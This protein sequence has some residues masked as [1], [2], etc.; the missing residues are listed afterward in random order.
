[1]SLINQRRHRPVWPFVLA[2]SVL[3]A[4][5]GAVAGFAYMVHRL[6]DPATP[7]PVGMRIDGSRVS[8]KFPTCPTD[9]VETVEVY[10]SDSEKLLW[11]AHGLKTSQRE[12]GTVTLWTADDFVKAA[13]ATRPG[14]LPKSLDVSVVTAIGSWPLRSIIGPEVVCDRDLL[15]I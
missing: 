7:S 13:P 14:I 5:L 15:V 4:V 10:D 12:R 2:G 8:V 1:M 11:R 9:R 6:S 3:L